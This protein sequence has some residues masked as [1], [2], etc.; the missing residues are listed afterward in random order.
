MIQCP[1]ADKSL[2]LT[3]QLFDNLL[4]TGYWIDGVKKSNEVGPLLCVGHEV[5]TDT[6]IA[7]LRSVKDVVQRLRQAAVKIGRCFEDAEQRGD[8][9]SICSQGS[10]CRSD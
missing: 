4:R 8:I 5:M 10:G 7:I 1:S 6:P 9:E 2:N 3:D